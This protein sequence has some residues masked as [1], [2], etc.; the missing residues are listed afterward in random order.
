MSIPV[1]DP[2]IIG[3]ST[4]L[5]ALPITANG[6]IDPGTIDRFLSKVFQHADDGMIS[7][8]GIGEK[9]TPQEGK[10]RQRVFVKPDQ[11]AAIVEHV[12]RWSRMNVAAFFVPAILHPSAAFAGDVA[13]DKIAGFTSIVLDLDTG[14]V[15]AKASFAQSRLGTP[16][17]VVFSGG[18]TD[19][20]QAKRHLWWCLNEATDEVERVGKLRKMLAAKTGGDQSFG[21]VT[22][23]IRIAGSIHSKN[24]NPNLVELVACNEYDYGLDDLAEII[25]GMAPM[26]GIEV[27]A[28]LL[29]TLSVV[30]GMDFTPRQDTA[31][32][33]L[34]RDVHEGGADLTRFSEFSK[35]AGFFISEVRAGRLVPERAYSDIKGWVLAHM[36]PPWPEA[37]AVQEFEALIRTDIANHGPFPQP[38]A[39]W[40]NIDPGAPLP[41]EHFADIKASLSNAWLVRNLLPVAGLA[42]IYGAP[43]SGK[44]FLALD[45]ALRIAGGTPIDGRSVQQCPV[46]YIAAEGQTGLRGRVVAFRRHHNIEGDL[47]FAM[48]PC[49][50]NL[51]DPNA[52][53][54]RVI[55]TIKRAS[56]RFG[57]DPGL[58]FV[59]TLAATFGGGD[60]NSTAMVAYINNLAKLRDAFKMTVVAVHH[61]PKDQLNDTL[62]GHGSLTGAMDTIIRVEAGETRSATITKQKDAD[63]GPTITFRLESVCLG[64][65]EE[66]EPVLSAVVE[67]LVA[68][69]S[70]RLTA[71]AARALVALED[72][73]TNAGGVPVSEAAWR[74]NWRARMPAEMQDEAARKSFARGRDSLRKGGRARNDAGLWAILVLPEPTP[75]AA[76]NPSIMDFSSAAGIGR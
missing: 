58:A 27:A 37:R 15:E 72:A 26:P 38:P 6:A 60:E 32:A 44:S 74:E 46:I 53:L 11:G 45:M 22:Q 49:A 39:N 64:V 47:P 9:G 75:V 40:S 65:D 24:G 55:E 14:D 50:V 43:G 57:A 54:P 17:M 1:A 42:A 35:V 48:V 59:D 51:L 25:E 33:A 2:A 4:R 68:P 18:T 12:L 41:L 31:I 10:F 5:S 30:G 29:P 67:Y 63:I 61:R 13:A 36:Q 70:D 28:P 16:S 69:A 19:A 3:G 76:T 62:R 21:R 56:E 34:H 66:K 73:I 23:V 52:D 7:L 20:G 8:L 71:A